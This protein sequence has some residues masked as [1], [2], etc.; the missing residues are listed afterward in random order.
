V[1][2]PRFL[3]DHDFN[4]HILD[5]V[6]RRAPLAEISRVREYGLHAEDDGAVLQ[7]AAE[8][9][10]IVLSHDVNTMPAAA[11]AR[12]GDGREM[13]GLLMVKQTD[14]IAAVIEDLVLIWSTSETEEWD[15]QVW[16]LPI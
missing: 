10:L 4:E 6:L 16:F 7:F 1:S 9:G 15:R 14:P 11:Y 12:M 8:N 2:R 5:G 3:A 13:R